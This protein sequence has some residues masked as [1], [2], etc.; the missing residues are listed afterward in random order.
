MERKRIARAVYVRTIARFHN[1]SYRTRPMQLDRRHDHD[2]YGWCI[3][4]ALG[5]LALALW[6]IGVP[7][8]YYFDEVHYVPAALKL[9]K[10]IPANREHPMFAK[11]VLAASIHLLGDRPFAWRI[12]SVMLG[13]LGLFAFSR[14]VWHASKNGW[15]TVAAMILLATNFMW[16][17]QS[18]IAMLDMT[19]ASLAMVALWQFGAALDAGSPGRARVRLMLAGLCMGLSIGAKWTSVPVMIVPGLTFLVLRLRESGWRIVGRSGAGPMPGISLAEAALWLGLFPLAVYWLTYLP[20]MFYDRKPVLP[21]D[22]IGQHLKMLKL[23]D[24]VTKAHPYRSVWYQWVT[25]WRPIWYLF[26][27][28]DGARRGIIMLGNP[29][30]LLTGLPA[31]FWA[32][33]AALRHRR[34]DALYFAVLYLLCIGMWVHNT[35]PVQFFYHYLLAA[36]FLMA[37]LA[38]A[39]E[40]L[41]RRK[42]RWRWLGA[43]TVAA[44]VA[45]F[46]LFYPIIAG[47]PL[48]YLKAYNFWM[49]SPTW[50]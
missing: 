20:A 28:I 32:L 25:D 21:F 6:R 38:L 33:W 49:W 41:S 42:D 30:T 50:R 35:K 44:S 37:V 11:E 27:N 14:S 39:L 13:T 48:P 29:L 47:Y 31:V 1:R 46:V 45:L 4:I 2:P 15:A 16:F 40:Q 34:Y 7:T 8:R 36:S 5:F 24:S 10:M 26:E 18:R 22:F 17:I 43:G 12:P 19:M 3:A 23:Q 9:L